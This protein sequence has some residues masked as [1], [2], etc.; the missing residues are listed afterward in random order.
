MVK[1]GSGGF[2]A[3]TF[4]G[5]SYPNDKCGVNGLPLTPNSIKIL[6]R[7]QKLKILVHPHLCHYID[8]VRGTHGKLLLMKNQIETYNRRVYL[9]IFKYQ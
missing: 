4:C 8:L 5:S 2:G 3:H 9:I 1:L 7:F 6:G